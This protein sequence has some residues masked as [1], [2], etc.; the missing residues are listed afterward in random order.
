MF[1]VFQSRQTRECGT[2][3][4]EEDKLEME[5]A[6]AAVNL[7]VKRQ[8]GNSY[9]FGIYFNVV[10]SNRTEEGGWVP[11]VHALPFYYFL[12]YF[13]RQ[14]QID[15]QITLLNSRFTTTKTRIR[16]HLL[17]VTRI[18][19]Q[20]WHE[21]VESLDSGEKCV[22]SLL[23]FLFRTRNYLLSSS[24]SVAMKTSLHKGRS[25][26]L[27][28]YTVSLAM[29]NGYATLP[30]SYARAPARDGIVLRFTTLPGGSSPERQGG[31][32][33]HEC[34]HWLG[35]LHT[36]DGGCTGTGDGVADTP[37]EASEARGCPIGRKSCPN[38][39]LP[40]PIRKYL[41]FVS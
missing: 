2:A 27:N 39:N 41:G 15:D 19:N 22:G 11:Y 10:A 9:D 36:F 40:D 17:N 5:K 12:T 30:G 13:Y 38:S 16:F 7:N 26:H 24:Q 32:L 21:N 25:I 23:Y 35:L 1:N 8:T 3:V 18:I 31:T 28:V 6:V 34:G 29:N 37:P 20:N 4:T 14:K 33:V